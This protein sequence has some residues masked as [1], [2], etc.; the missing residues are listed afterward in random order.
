MPPQDGLALV[1]SVLLAWF[2][3]VALAFVLPLL[4]PSFAALAFVFEVSS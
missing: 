1:G 2:C 4:L 3:S